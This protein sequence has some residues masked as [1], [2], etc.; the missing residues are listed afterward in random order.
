MTPEEIL[1]EAAYDSMM[2]TSLEYDGEND[3]VSGFIAGSE[4]ESKHTLYKLNF[5]RDRLLMLINDN[6]DQASRIIK[7]FDVEV[8][9]KEGTK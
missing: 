3:Y 1:K 9:L 6:P 7:E 2:L 8:F 4:Y 5:L